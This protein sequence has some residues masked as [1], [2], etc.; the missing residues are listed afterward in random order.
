MG[1]GFLF[2]QYFENDPDLQ[3]DGIML[4]KRA[5][6]VL[7]TPLIFCLTLPIHYTISSRA[8]SRMDTVVTHDSGILHLAILLRRRVVAL[9]GPTDPSGRVPQ[10][11]YGRVRIFWYGSSISCCPCY[12]GK[13]FAKCDN[14]LCLDRIPVAEVDAVLEGFLGSPPEP[15]DA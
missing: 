7:R 2:F 11:S 6:N 4:S 8:L 15:R 10:N 14:N 1:H 13:T 9:F 3:F 12:D 5:H